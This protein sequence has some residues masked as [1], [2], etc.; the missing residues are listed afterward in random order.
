MIF[1]SF[2]KVFLSLFFIPHFLFSIGTDSLITANHNST[3]NYF[4][5]LQFESDISAKY[6]D[7]SLTNFQDYQ[8]RNHLGNNGLPNSAFNS[9]ILINPLSFGF[10]YSKNNYENN[11]F[12]PHKVVFYN[13]RIPFTDLFYVTGSKLEQNFKLIFSY[14][15]KK[16]WNLTANFN[17]IRSDGFYLRQNTNSNF[18]ELSSNFKSLNNVYWFLASL[19][20]NNVKNSENG[21]IINDSL[22]EKTNT[23]DKKIID[24]SLNSAKRTTINR[25]FYFKQ[26]FNFG[27]RSL[28][29]AAHNSIVPYSRFVLTS[30]VDDNKFKYQDDNPLSG[31]YKDIYIDST[32]TFDSIYHL[33]I[34]NELAWKRVCS[35]NREGLKG[36]L[37]LGF[38]FKDQFVHIRQQEITGVNDFI[39][40]STQK[41][42]DTIFNNLIV[43]AEFYNLYSKNKFWW[44]ISGKYTLSGYNMDDYFASTDFKKV[45]FDSLN[46]ITI[47]AF[48]DRHSPDFIY[49]RFLAN[50]FCWQNNFSKMLEAN[51]GINFHMIK[52]HFSLGVNLAQYSNILY[53]DKNAKAKQFLGFIPV[54]TAFVK[55][56]ISF[57]NWHFNNKVNYQFISD[58]A[59]IRLPEFVLEHSVFYENN[60]FRGAVKF[61]IG[62]ALFYNSAYYANAYM[63]ATAQFYLQNEKKYGDY[64]F[65]DFFINAQIKTVRV[66]IK[67]DHL[68]S[69]MMGNYYILTPRYPMND[70]ALKLGVSWR[71]FD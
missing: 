10:K 35:K 32:R 71:F 25:S 63:P 19:N 64:P 30:L 11:F 12:S 29:S 36:F 61:Q 13:T 45:F 9:P 54:F 22:F 14:N 38:S 50:N 59:V 26:Y 58:S 41:K 17:R 60:L 57:H 18:I 65:I 40:K 69:G 55:K 8:N 70:R 7:L 53:F 68:N 23:I 5:E 24:V 34:E 28:D 48:V 46:V 44:I 6:I 42:V 37:G 27:E 4:S 20:Y 52:Y 16:N 51:V 62:A 1:V 67:V 49:N 47:K 56:D 21:G 15:I 2:R 31:Y 66:F 43:G 33:R 3:T 39:I